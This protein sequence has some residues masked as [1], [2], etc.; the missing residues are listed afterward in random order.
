MSSQKVQEKYRGGLKRGTA[1]EGI[2]KLLPYKGKTEDTLESILGGVRSGLTYSGARTI[3]ELYQ[4]SE[5]YI[6]KSKLQ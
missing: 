5:Y 4:N 1:A 2:D 6:L 3:E